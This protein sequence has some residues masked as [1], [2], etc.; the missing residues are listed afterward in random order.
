MTRRFEAFP[1]NKTAGVQIVEDGRGIETICLTPRREWSKEIAAALNLRDKD[2][3]AIAA[4]LGQV[5]SQATAIDASAEDIAKAIKWHDREAKSAMN[6]LSCGSENW[7]YREARKLATMH[8]LAASALRTVAP[9]PDTPH[10]EPVEGRGSSSQL[11]S[12]Q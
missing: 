3:A 12:A 11:R 8:R 4:E 10:P 5:M 7:E 6:S 2:R 9:Q 1:D